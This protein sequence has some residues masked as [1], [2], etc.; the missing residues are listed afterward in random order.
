[1]QAKR[2]PALARHK[3]TQTLNLR[4]NVFVVNLNKHKIITFLIILTIFTLLLTFILNRTDT[5]KPLSPGDIDPK[6]GCTLA[7][8][9]SGLICK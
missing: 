4:Y 3:A 8:D 1:M 6:T 7:D 5:P 2:N 9:E